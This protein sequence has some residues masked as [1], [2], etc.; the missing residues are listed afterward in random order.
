MT[1]L[2]SPGLGRV[3]AE[4]FV[5]QHLAHLA[6]DGVRG[7]ESFTGGQVAADSALAA[8]DVTGY[9]ARRNEV[10]PP[11]R[12][13]A[14][15]LSPHIRHGLLSLAEVWDHVADGPHRDVE[16]FR[17]ELLWQEY[18]RH[19]YARLGTRTRHNTRHRLPES[20]L[21][22]GASADKGWSLQ[23][24]C[25]DLAVS[26]LDRDGWLVNQTRM[27]LAG[28]WTV[29]EGLRWTDGED[30]F[31]RHLLDGSRAANRLGWQWVT[32]A[33]SSKPYGFSRHQVERRAPG[34]CTSCEL[35]DACPI[36]DWPRDPVLEPIGRVDRLHVGPSPALSAGPAGPAGVV[37]NETPDAVWLTA[38]SLGHRDPALSAHPHLPVLFVFDERLLGSLQL[39]SKRLVFIT[40]TLAELGVEHDLR[41]SLGDPV[42]I[43]AGREL[44]VTFAPVPGFRRLAERLQPAELHPWPWLRRPTAGP[45]ESFSAWRRSLG[46]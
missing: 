7:S 3:A 27:W 28:H 43:L 37:A 41:V 5:A 23:L 19:W 29:R 40:E 12:R 46:L 15:R 22:T 32:A 39:S 25:L 17:D 21:A 38:E 30:Y 11:P 18:A 10:Y 44:A 16:K 6:C 36:E 14:S 42:E 45:I 33:G 1:S 34:I 2:P 20:D 35:R 13:G 24:A 31:F 4:A 9:A 26:E 8:F